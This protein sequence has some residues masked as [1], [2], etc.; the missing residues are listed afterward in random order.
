MGFLLEI[1]GSTSMPERLASPP[2]DSLGRNRAVQVLVGRL[3]PGA[4]GRAALAAVERRSSLNDPRELLE[5][6]F[7][8]TTKLRGRASD[9]WRGTAT[10]RRIQQSRRP[11]GSRIRIGDCLFLFVH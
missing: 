7:E 6:D 9:P 1:Y 3:V 5:R 4:K 10:D 11:F 2:S 8:R